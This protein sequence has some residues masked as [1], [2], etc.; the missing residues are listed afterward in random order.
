M[1]SARIGIAEVADAD[2]SAAALFRR[3][4]GQEPPAFPHHIVASVREAG[5]SAAQALCYV[6]FTPMGSIL[7]GG[8]AC[9][10][11]R[12]LRQ[13]SPDQRAALRAYGGLYRMTL[14][15]AVTHFSR[16]HEAIFG[17]CGD[18]LAER[19]DLAA[20]FIRTGHRHLLV[21]WLRPLP[22]ARQQELTASVH[23]L[24]AF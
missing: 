22:P 24:G 1:S 19:I 15:W 20:G 4:F 13:L 8:G 14:D 3:R 9:V 10:D 18:H 17:Y 23:A 6:H 2:G 11:N 12:A 21:R 7:L 5:S 16:N